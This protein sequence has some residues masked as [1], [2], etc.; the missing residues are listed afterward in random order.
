MLVTL[1]LFN[2]AAVRFGKYVPPCAALPHPLPA[3]HPSPYLVETVRHTLRWLMCVWCL[4]VCMCGWH[5]GQNEALPI[6][7]NAIVPE[8]IA[9]ILSVSFVL[10][11]GEIIPSAVFTGPKRLTIGM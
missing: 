2:S 4:C 5:F 6:F 10:V 11:F 9:I 8:Y 1:L 7:L 3:L